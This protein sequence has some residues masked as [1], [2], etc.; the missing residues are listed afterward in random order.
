[1]AGSRHELLSLAEQ[2]RRE[3]AALPFRFRKTDLTITTSIGAIWTGQARPF[4]D[5]YKE[6]DA[7]LYRAKE[8]GRNRVVLASTQEDAGETVA[9]NVPARVQGSAHFAPA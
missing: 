7:A 2:L 3:I 1:M 8:G 4:S 5:L 6:A 9:P